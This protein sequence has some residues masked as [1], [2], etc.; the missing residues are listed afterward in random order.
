M[1][2]KKLMKED[3]DDSYNL[4]IENGALNLVKGIKSD[5]VMSSFDPGENRSQDGSKSTINF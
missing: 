3:N 5:M 2:G 1:S 4:Q